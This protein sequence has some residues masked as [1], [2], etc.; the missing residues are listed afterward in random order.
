MRWKVLS[1]GVPRTLAVVF[2]VGDEPVRMLEQLASQEGLTGSQVTGIGGFE[3][4]TL[5]YFDWETKEYLRIPVD[6]QVE[7]VSLVG[8]LTEGDGRARL[9]A[10]AVVSFR[11]GTTRAGHLL[12]A[13]VRPTLEVV[14][15][16]APT[17]L[18]R[19][20]DAATGLALLD[21]G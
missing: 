20:S 19:R 10:H 18:E 21:L 15:T 3:R 11:D 7:V 12:E 5:G 17:G 16:D 14:V 13:S 6:T 9:H 4:A 8:D 1:G 2:D